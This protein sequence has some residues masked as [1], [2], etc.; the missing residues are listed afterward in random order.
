VERKLKIEGFR[1]GV[2]LILKSRHKI[3]M[4]SQLFAEYISTV[5]L[6]YFAVG[7]Q[8]VTMTPKQANVTPRIKGT[9]KGP[10]RR[11]NRRTETRRIGKKRWKNGNER[12]D[13]NR[14]ACEQGN[15][16]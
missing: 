4:N 1:M 8:F 6:P 5:L 3:Y 14:Q 13:R 9:E 16:N 10:K 7:T 2:D 15:I 12:K 11:R